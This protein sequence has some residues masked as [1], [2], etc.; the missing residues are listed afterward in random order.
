M[1]VNV[2]NGGLN[3]EFLEDK[4]EGEGKTKVGREQRIGKANGEKR[5]RVG[6]VR[7][8]CC[9]RNDE[10]MLTIKKGQKEGNGKERAR[11]GR[12]WKEQVN[13][14]IEKKAMAG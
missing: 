2:Q 12:G 6:N 9:R 3:S 8:G 13:N 10:G 14:E 7:G 5:A 11:G 4:K 1:A